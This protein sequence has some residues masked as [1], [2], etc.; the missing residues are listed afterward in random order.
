MFSIL[1][2]IELSSFWGPFKSTCAAKPAFYPIFISTTRLELNIIAGGKVRLS[3]QQCI[4][5]YFVTSDALWCF[6]FVVWY[7]QQA[8]TE[9]KV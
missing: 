1:H 3:F 8:A 9:K 2:L 4:H 6:M 7:G 5:I